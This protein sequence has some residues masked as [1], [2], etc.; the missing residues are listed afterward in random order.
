[1][2]T[3][4]QPV[5]PPRRNAKIQQHGNCKAAPLP[6]D[7]AIRSIRRQGRSKWKQESGYHRR[8]RAESALSRFKRILGRTLRTRTLAHQKTEVRLG[9]QI[10]NR[11]AS[12]GMPRTVAVAA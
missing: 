6:R 11:M 7:E 1:M 10:L 4:A 5:I 8:S 2:P 3:R 12:L 9:S